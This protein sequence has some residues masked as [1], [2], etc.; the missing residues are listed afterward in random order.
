MQVATGSG[1]V[2]CPVF[3]WCSLSFRLTESEHEGHR[4]VK[5]PPANCEFQ[6]MLFLMI[7][8]Y[9]AL[10]PL[11]T[12]SNE[13]ALLVSSRKPSPFNTNKLINF[14]PVNW[15]LG[16]HLEYTC[17]LQSC[18]VCLK[19]CLYFLLNGICTKR[20]LHTGYQIPPFIYKKSKQTNKKKP[21]YSPLSEL[22]IKTYNLIKLKYISGIMELA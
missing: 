1:M 13:F 7:F 21:S 11:L 19:K 10:T 8:F 20:W 17:R 12:L 3:C 9:W 2:Q 4:R 6:P 18:E 15:T 16:D 5:G 14:L 22:G